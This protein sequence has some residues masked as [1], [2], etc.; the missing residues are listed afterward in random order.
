MR[1][2]T[3][4]INVLNPTTSNFNME[5]FDK[6]IPELDYEVEIDQPEECKILIHGVNIRF[7]NLLRKTVISRLNTMAIDLVEIEMNTTALPDETIA[8]RLGMVPIKCQTLDDF[9]VFDTCSCAGSGCEHCSVSFTLDVR[10]TSL[11]KRKITS[12]DIHFSDS[13]CSVI[14]GPPFTLFYLHYGERIFLTGK[15]QKAT[16]K[17]HVKWCP[18]SG[19]FFKSVDKTTFS[20]H[21]ESTG[22]LTNAE[23]IEQTLARLRE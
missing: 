18:V 4:M 12:D 13:N 14:S 8:H 17:R 21:F 10:G 6:C 3:R 20:F 22:H 1:L 23:I 16:G 9:E 5:F 11:E 2:Q 15:V 19:V 7:V